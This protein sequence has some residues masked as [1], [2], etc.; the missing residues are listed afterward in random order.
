MQI[1]A[2][3]DTAPINKAIHNIKSEYSDREEI[4]VK[5]LCHNYIC[6]HYTAISILAG[7]NNLR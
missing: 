1:I 2:D 3:S 4:F 6:M 7:S 5:T